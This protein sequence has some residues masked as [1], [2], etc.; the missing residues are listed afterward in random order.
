MMVSTRSAFIGLLALSAVALLALRRESPARLSSGISVRRSVSL[1]PRTAV[2][3]TKEAMRP[4]DSVKKAA[5]GLALAASAALAAHQPAMADVSGLTKC[6]ESPA[7]KKRETKEIKSLEKQLS[8]TPQ[9]SPGYLELSNR[10]ERTKKRFNTYSKTSLLC[11]PD[12]LPHLIVGP[13]FRGHEGEFAIPALGFLYI[14]GWIGW[15][16][17]KYI[18]GNRGETSKPTVLPFFLHFTCKRAWPFHL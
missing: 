15:A 2:C 4:V 7:F 16:G 3:A 12:G 1:P 5:A 13:E 8:K 14:N 17:R 9:G 6:S 11:G 18:R 10:I